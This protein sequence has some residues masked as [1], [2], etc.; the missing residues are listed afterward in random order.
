MRTIEYLLEVTVQ[1]NPDEVD[2]EEK[3]VERE[4]L[5][6]RAI[7]NIDASIGVFQVENF[8]EP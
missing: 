2:T 1:V 4:K 6:R 3:K 7:E 8:Q 5:I